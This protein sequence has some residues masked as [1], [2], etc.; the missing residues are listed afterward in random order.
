MPDISNVGAIDYSSNKAPPKYKCSECG[1]SGVRLYR[2]Y[3]TF[4][5]NS[6]LNCTKCALE[7][8]KRSHNGEEFDFEG[9]DIAHSIGWVIAAVPCEDGRHYWGYTSVPKEGVDWWE[10]LPEKP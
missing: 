8:Y 3:Q 4:L 6:S 10:R 2:E 9:K 1:V 7:R 5:N